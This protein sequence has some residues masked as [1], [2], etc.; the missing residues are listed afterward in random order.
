[1]STPVDNLNAALL[2]GFQAGRVRL[3]HRKIGDL[4]ITSGRLVGCDPFVCPEAAPFSVQLPNGR[5]PLVLSLAETGTDQRVAFA[6]LRISD[7]TPVR[8]EMLTTRDR[9]PSNLKDDEIVGYG[10]DSGTGCFADC[11]AAALFS[12]KMRNDA[13][14]FDILDDEM[15][16]TYRHTWSWLNVE[17][18]QANLIA[19]SSGYGDGV[20]ATYAG[21]DLEGRLSCVVTDFDVLPVED[22]NVAPDPEPAKAKTLTT[23]WKGLFG[24]R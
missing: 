2:D 12:S 4:I 3:I 21:F 24:K 22:E 20:Y 14:Y 7:S 5:L 23:F 10:V 13:N 18:G 15:Q 1:M 16:K 19:F 8:W 6:V 9:L 11:T 17:L